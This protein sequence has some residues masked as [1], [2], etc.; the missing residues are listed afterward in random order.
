MYILSLYLILYGDGYFLISVL[1]VL[2]TAHL[3]KNKRQIKVEGNNRQ[4]KE[5]PTY[6]EENGLGIATISMTLLQYHSHFVMLVS[7]SP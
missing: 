7:S 6:C 1:V 4:T 2:Y 3:Q 5:T